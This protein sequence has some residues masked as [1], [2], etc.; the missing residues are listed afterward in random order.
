MGEQPNLQ[1]DTGD[2]Q[3]ACGDESGAEYFCDVFGADAAD[4][5]ELHD[6]FV[7]EAVDSEK[8]Q[9]DG[10]NFNYCVLCYNF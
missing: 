1:A 10:A 8:Y 6:G 7:V 9:D 2:L 3:Y 5:V 4:D